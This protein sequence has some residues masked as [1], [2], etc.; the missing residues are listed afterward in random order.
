M[1]IIIWI[2]IIAAFVMS[3]VSIVFPVLPGPLMI[4]V[5]YLLYAFF[6]DGGALS[7]VFW[8]S[9][10]LLSVLLIV[11]DIIANSY[12]VK[13]YGGSKW[14]ER[15]AGIA[16]IVGSFIFPPFGLI[17]VPFI[18]VFIT[19]LLQKKTSVDALK[20]AFGSLMGFLGG[21]VAKIVIQVV[22]I[23]WFFIDI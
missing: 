19:E 11:S 2:L 17:I 22:M 10:V 20:V 8:I 5:G 18:V 6:I 12:F 1:D 23:I 3:F 21:T 9:M 16:V 15:M 7:T 4:W 14:S 13:R